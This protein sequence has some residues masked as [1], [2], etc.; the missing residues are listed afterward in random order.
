MLVRRALEGIGRLAL[1]GLLSTSTAACA[2]WTGGLPRGTLEEWRVLL[3]V[4]PIEPSDLDRLAQ[5]IKPAPSEEAFLQ[6][7]WET[8]L[9]AARRRA[10]EQGLPIL[11]FLMSGHPLGCT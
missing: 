9:W 5:L 2:T 11:A 3:S 10:A 8:S 6:I 1:A 7:P 4:P